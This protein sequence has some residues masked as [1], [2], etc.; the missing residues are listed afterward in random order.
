MAD[1]LARKKRAVIL[2]GFAVITILN[3]RAG[4]LLYGSERW[5]WSLITAVVVTGLVGPV[6]LYMI[7]NSSNEG[8]APGDH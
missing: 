2:V 6:V 1:M 8:P 3:F 5:A 4:I 7:R